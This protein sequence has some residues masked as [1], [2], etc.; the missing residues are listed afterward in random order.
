MISSPPRLAAQAP[1]RTLAQLFQLLLLAEARLL[2][3]H[4]HS[5]D[6]V[7]RNSF[8]APDRIDVA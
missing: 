3:Q 4:A 1:Q 6:V 5:E 7:A 8:V 2:P